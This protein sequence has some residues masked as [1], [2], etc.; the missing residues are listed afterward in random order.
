MA[1]A[2]GPAEHQTILALRGGGRIWAVAAVHGEADRLG[3]LH[4]QLLA[5]SQAGDQLVYLGNLLGLGPKVKEALDAALLFRRAF[6]A[7]PGADAADLVF[8]RG[9]QEEMWQK[10]LQLQFAT[11]PAQVYDW[12]VSQGIGPT[13]AAYG[14]TVE[15]GRLAIKEGILALTRWTSALRAA[16]RGHDGHA[17]YLS[18]LRHAAHS[19]EGGLLFVHAGIDPTRPLAAQSDSFWWG[20]GGFSDLAQPYG[21]FVKVVRGFERKHAG[22][23]T[24]AH[25]VTLDGGAGFGGALIAARFEADGSVGEILKA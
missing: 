17:Q 15:E 4:A 12:M 9:A 14:G 3:D 21:G 19:G 5:K 16:F 25:T 18:A 23:R 20:G 10:L 24:D 13:I 11:G 8:L 22:P 1:G 6:I 2:G 7:R